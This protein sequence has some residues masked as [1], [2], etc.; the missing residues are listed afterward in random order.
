MI[1]TY[2]ELC[3]LK[4][5]EER[6]RYLKLNG[7]V[8][9]DTFGWQRYLNQYLYKNNPLWRKARDE[10]IARDNGNDL[11]IKGR[12][13]YGKILVHHMNPITIND[14]RS[15]N[16]DIFNPEYL[17]STSF[18]THQAIHYGNESMLIL[19]ITERSINDTCPWKK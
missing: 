8:G 17:I 19:D 18:D 13:I 2:S 9:D 14:I 3:R 12:D 16:P 6:Y 10:V 11:G 15:G 1:R 4:T 7:V 5:F